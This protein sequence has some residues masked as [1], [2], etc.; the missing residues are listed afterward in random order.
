MRLSALVGLSVAILSTTAGGQ[1]FELDLSD[2][3]VPG[4]FR[5]SIAV[6]GIASKEGPE[7]TVNA[8]RATLLENELVKAVAGNAAFGK[9]MNPAEVGAILGPAKAAALKCLD[10]ACLDALART[11]KVD[12]LIK[13]T[14][15]KSGVV[16]LLT[17]YGFDPGETEVVS[18]YVESSERQEKAQIGGFAGISGKSQAAKDRE[19]AKKAV[20]PFFD[21][22]ERIKTPNG[23]IAVD[24]AELTAV[25]T[26]NDGE[27]GVG[28]FE[29]VIS[30]GNYEVKV[31]AA[32]YLPF[33]AK[34][35]VEPQKTAV[36]K[37]LL[38]AKP[39]ENAGAVAEVRQNGTPA[40]ARPGLY[41]AIAGAIA[42]GVGIG[43]GMS[44]K[45][46]EARAIPNGDGVVPISRTAAKGAQ[47]SALV[48]NILVGAG[49]VAIAGGGVW[50][51][52]T[53]APSSTKKKAEEPN[54]TE[55]GGGFGVMVGYQGT[56]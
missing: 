9:V 56:F 32:G 27:L 15:A 14:V 34:V 50:F 20:P 22:M 25:A 29:K 8:N 52:L 19:F 30:R 49:A 46:T 24:S 13:G 5:P 23:K 44:A 1:G 40:I 10:Y 28:S 35:V 4:E 3:E 12:R 53:P 47:S 54:A 55:G 7:D 51:F 37:V 43:V 16:S 36:V 26:L 33:E 39:L 21:I 45:G 17:V 6:I 42:V 31:T 41:I 2:P 38:V 18:T 48:S 11:L